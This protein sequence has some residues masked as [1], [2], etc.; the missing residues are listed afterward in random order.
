ML[1]F[2]SGSLGFRVLVCPKPCK[3]LKA[4][5][6]TNVKPFG[7]QKLQY[8][9]QNWGYFD[10]ISHAEENEEEDDDES[11]TGNPNEEP[12]LSDISNLSQF[13]YEKMGGP[14]GSYEDYRKML[15]QSELGDL[16]ALCRLGIT[17]LEGV[18]GLVAKD[19]DK[20]LELL[21]SAGM[22]GFASA[23]YI[24]GCYWAAE[25]VETRAYPW[26]E[27][28]A[29]MGDSSAMYE[30]AIRLSEGK[31]VVKNKQQVSN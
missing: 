2:R 6:I 27:R 8:G 9:T 28:A 17:Y 25:T 3:Y 10:P 21:Y 31:G 20:G 13:M 11:I 29:E 15:D 24:M 1:A 18:D 23:F 7:I 4:C 5:F 30:L 26:F 16:N 12:S 19:V 22:K 14:A